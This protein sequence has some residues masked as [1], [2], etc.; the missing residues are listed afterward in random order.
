MADVRVG[1]VERWYIVKQ[2]S[3]GSTI[4]SFS[5]N[6]AGGIEVFIMGLS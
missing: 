4:A 6:V 5:S 2:V 3:F 1:G